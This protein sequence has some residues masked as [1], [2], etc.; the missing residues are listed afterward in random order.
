MAAEE[1]IDG[2]REEVAVERR[3]LVIK[4]L[5]PRFCKR[6][7]LTPGNGLDFGTR[8]GSDYF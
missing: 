3:R 8:G 4:G 1:A 5:E 7:G 6:R 2:W